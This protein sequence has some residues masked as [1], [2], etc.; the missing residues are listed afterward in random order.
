MFTT[1]SG[2]VSDS[3]FFIRDREFGIVKSSNRENK[4]VLFTK[5][6]KSLLHYARGGGAMKSN[7]LT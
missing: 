7:L 2:K 6:D 3:F 1:K 4:T 5:K